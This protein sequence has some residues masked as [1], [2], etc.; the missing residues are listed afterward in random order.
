MMSVN[1]GIHITIERKENNMKELFEYIEELEWNEYKAVHPKELD[2]HEI[3][4]QL[5][6]LMLIA[7]QEWEEINAW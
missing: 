3:C 5:S 4:R 1:I 7:K 6:Y 2:Y